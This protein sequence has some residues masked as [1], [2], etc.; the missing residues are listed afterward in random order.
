MKKR[1]PVLLI[2]DTRESQETKNMLFSNNIDFIEYNIEK[3]GGSCCRHL[4]TTSAPSIFAP[5]GV[6]RGKDSIEQYIIKLMLNTCKNQN[7]LE[8]DK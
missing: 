2:D 6:Y 5:E 7:I 3:F 4:P 8:L 1:K